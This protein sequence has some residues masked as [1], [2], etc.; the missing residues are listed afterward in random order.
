[1]LPLLLA[2]MLAEC[3]RARPGE[4][5]RQHDGEQEREVYIRSRRAIKTFVFWASTF[6]W[7]CIPYSLTGEPSPKSDLSQLPFP[8][9]CPTARRRAAVASHE[10]GRSTECCEQRS[11]K[12]IGLPA[13]S[14]TSLFPESLSGV[15]S[16]PAPVPLR[17]RVHPPMSFTSPTE[18]QPLRTCPALA[19]EDASLGVPLPIATSAERVHLRASVPS[20]PYG[21][22][23][24]FLTPSAICSSLYLAGLFHPAATSGIH[25]PGVFSRHPA[26]APRRHPVPSCRLAA[27][28]YRRVASTAPA[29]PT[30]PPGL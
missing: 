30:P 26:R 25:L 22:P 3:G 16:P 4:L 11:C 5:E 2:P 29:P 21:P 10:V 20:S 12:P 8:V 9:R 24:A 28:A 18:Y 15:T 6:R 23:S 13:P 27:V 7:T 19:C 14:M 17:V 1:V